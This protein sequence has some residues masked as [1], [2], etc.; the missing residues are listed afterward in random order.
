MSAAMTNTA[1]AA[2][3]STPA[4][5]IAYGRAILCGWLVVALS[6]GGLG[7]WSVLAPLASAAMA[8]GALVVDGARKSVQHLEGGIVREILVR[9]GDLVEAG[10][11]LLQLDGAVQR[12]T[13]DLIRGRFDADRAFEA[14]LIAER[15]GRAAVTFPDD[16]VEK[17][18]SNADVA[19]MLLGQ[20]AIFEARRDSQSVEISILEN[21][22]QQSQAQ[23]DGL[24]VEQ[25]SKTRQGEL[26]Q[27]ELDGL[28]K[29]LENG[30]AAKNKV[31]ALERELEALTG[32]RG[33]IDARI[34]GVGQAIG[35]AQLQ[36]AQ[37]KKA[38]I[39][40]VESDLR[41]VQTEIFDLS[42]RADTAAEELRRL[43]I[44]APVDGVVVDLAIHT[45]GG[46]IAPG[47]RVLDIVPV[48]D[49]LIVEARVSPVDIKDIHVGLA[50]Q[51]R[52]PAFAQDSTPTIRGEVLM[53]S[54]DRLVDE[55]SDVPYYL[56][57][58]AVPEEEGRKLGDDELV[59]GMPVEVILPK[60]ERTLADYML[61]PIEDTFVA[62][63]R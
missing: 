42:Q 56:V 30:H 40:D 59:P 20:T 57:H 39:E 14:R 19:Q 7:L 10:Q 18:A 6:F 28:R 58:V 22:I 24:L 21:R 37:L 48:D 35:E 33:E 49:R 13:L 44:T 51:L 47:S 23:I 60:Q 5:P 27:D 38:F 8:P 53:V 32:A 15:D 31:L 29:L 26:L 17:A 52:F 9:D 61:G 41:D 50:A 1:R 11:V 16:L 62:A 25:T 34:A 55:R 3:A 2:A 36:I 45:E 46:V 63:F 54:A 12:S 4:F 43:S